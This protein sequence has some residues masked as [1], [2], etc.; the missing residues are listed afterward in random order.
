VVIAEVEARIERTLVGRLELG[1]HKGIFPGASASVAIWKDGAWV[2]VDQTAGSLIGEDGE[3]TAG[4]IYDLASLTKPLVATAALRLHHRG[5]LALDA[6]VHE[7]VPE[8]RGLALGARTWEAVWSH[9]AGLR[10]WEPF[11]ET[12]PHPPGSAAAQAWVLGE[13][14]RHGEA[15]PEGAAVYSDLGYILGGVA[16]SRAAGIRLDEI[17]T[18]E[19]CA[20]LGLEDAVFF[21]TSR[22]DESWKTR[23]A[24]TGRSRWRGRT[25]QGE[26]HD[27]NCAALGGVAGHAGMFGTARGMARFGAAC[28]GAWHGRR[29]ASDEALI[30]HATAPRAG[31]TQR[32]GWDGKTKRDSAAGTR[33]DRSA[34][35]HLGFTGTSIWCDPRRQLVVVLLTNRVAVSD[36]NA[37]IRAYR[38]AFHDAVV[39]AFDGNQP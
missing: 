26:V 33:I 34:F 4:T 1:R 37:A 24:P 9:R 30:R 15:N 8:A 23:C 27:D 13:L 29:G 16:L 11:Y 10:A 18:G 14:L 25:L 35:G 6:P 31:G 5:V 19:V 2:Y 21:G 28:I 17:V 36:D 12:L 39:D 32:L 22:A 7:S 20:P 3:V 38:P